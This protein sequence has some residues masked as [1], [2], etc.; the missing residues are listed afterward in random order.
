MTEIWLYTQSWNEERVLPFFFRHYDRWID[1]YIVYD[2]GSTDRTLEMFAAHPN[3]EV[4]QFERLVA[5]SFV[6]SA[7]VL[8]NTV[9]K[10]ARGKADWVVITAIDEHLHH[11]DILDYLA[12]CRTAGVSAIP[13]LGFQML[14]DRFPDSTEWLAA[15]ECIGAPY[16]EMNKLSIFDPNLIEETNFALG[17]HAAEP[18]GRVVYPTVDELVNLHYKYLGRD[19][20]RSR[21]SLLLSGLGDLDKALGLG[22]HYRLAAD[23]LDAEWQK[24]AAAALDYRDPT[25]GI[26]TH[27]ERWWRRPRLATT[28]SESGESRKPRADPRDPPRC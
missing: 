7:M 14:A 8:H 18:T 9:W 3:V 11:S 2:D 24:F 17:R 15:S 4:R 19:Y 16:I 22:W 5:D 25:V 1:R 23:E 20:V 27:V 6:G 28:S 10:E 13:A 21:H 12:R 26:T